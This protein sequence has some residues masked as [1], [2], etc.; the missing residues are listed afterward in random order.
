MTPPNASKDGSGIDWKKR[1]FGE[2]FY[3]GKDELPI[4]CLTFEEIE[5]IMKQISN[6]HNSPL[7]LDFRIMPD[8]SAFRLTSQKM[9]PSKKEGIWYYSTLYKLTCYRSLKY[10]GYG[11]TLEYANYTTGGELWCISATYGYEI[12]EENAIPDSNKPFFYKGRQ[13]YYRTEQPNKIY[14]MKYA[15]IK[16]PSNLISSFLKFYFELKNGLTYADAWIDQKFSMEVKC[17]CGH[18]RQIDSTMLVNWLKRTSMLNSVMSRLKCSSCGKKGAVNIFPLYSEHT[19]Q[20]FIH[21]T[22]LLPFKYRAKKQGRT[23]PFNSEL[24]DMY[25]NVGGDGE[26]PIYLS[27][28]A[29]LSPDGKISGD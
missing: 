12:E 22:A 2:N 14:E 21:K 26:N 11:S 8:Q 17:K 20:R 6:R 23:A 4:E 16:D 13:V 9:Q 25:G 28:G 27:D 15:T 19:P 29:Y 10:Q 3:V 18:E 24:K 1:A 5:Y 7:G